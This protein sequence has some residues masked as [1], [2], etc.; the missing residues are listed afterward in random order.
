MHCTAPS[1]LWPWWLLVFAG[2]AAHAAAANM[3]ANVAATNMVLR[4]CICQICSFSFGCRCAPLLFTCNS[5]RAL[6]FL[7]EC[8]PASCHNQ[9]NVTAHWDMD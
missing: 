5:V 1:L 3:A 8:C 7:I 6:S 4:T 9:S 2:M